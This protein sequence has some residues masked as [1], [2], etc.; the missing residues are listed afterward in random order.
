MKQELIKN[1]TKFQLEIPADEN[2]LSEVR[3]F[4]ADICTRAGFS[5]RETNNTKLAMDEACTNIIKHAYKDRSGSIKI[6]VTARPGHIDINV[7]D[8]GRAFEWSNVKDPDLQRYVEIGKK[9]GLGIYLMNRL[10][11][12]L[13]YTSTGQGNTLV[14]SKSSESALGGR[15][16]LFLSMKPKWTS[17]LRFKFA[18]RAGLGLFA[19]V[20][21]LW[22]VQFLNQTREIEAQENQAWLTMSNLARSLETKSESAITKDDLYDP[23]YRE[24][25]DYIQDRL[26]KLVGIEYVRVINS[27]GIIVS[28]SNV[29]EFLDRL[30][31]SSEK[32]SIGNEGRWFYTTGDD[33]AGIN[34]FHYPIRL[35]D[36][37]IETESSL[38]RVIMGVSVEAI[39]DSIYDP[40]PK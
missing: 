23:E 21:F 33:G 1:Q 22:I 27:D 14:M 36:E 37:S 5:K 10:M 6:D 25:N 7:F 18:M 15:D 8:R 4:I 39:K 19:L 12:D 35:S 40:R 13:D 16:A 17:T 32:D 3:D 31:L 11:D 2:N 28:S 24:I 38:G 29:D 26:I 34:E 30:Q 20:L 9:G